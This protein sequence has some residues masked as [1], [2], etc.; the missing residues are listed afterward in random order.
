[1]P[2]SARAICCWPSPRWRAPLRPS[3]LLLLLQL[4]ERLRPVL[5]HQ[6]RQHAVGEQ[7]AAGLAGGAVIGLVLGVEDALHRRAADGAGLAVAA[8]HGHLRAE[9]GDLL[10]EVVAGLRAQAGDPLAQHLLRRR[11]EP[12]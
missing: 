1:M 4:L 10:G 8:V 7:A 9:G 6:P 12:R 5:L 11:E 2:T 3:A